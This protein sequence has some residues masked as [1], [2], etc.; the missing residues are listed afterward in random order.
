MFFGVD[1]INRPNNKNG[2]LTVLKSFQPI[3]EMGRFWIPADIM[4]NF[5]EELVTE[6]SMI[7][8]DKILLSMMT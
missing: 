7:T 8:V 3:V 4:E 5:T 2:K 1:M 6:M